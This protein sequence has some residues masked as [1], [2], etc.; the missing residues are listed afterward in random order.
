MSPISNQFDM[1]NVLELNDREVSS[2]R[3][4]TASE[5]HTNQVSPR[6]ASIF[7]RNNCGIASKTL[8]TTSNEKT[9]RFSLCLKNIVC[10]GDSEISSIIMSMPPQRQIIHASP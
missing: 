6:S 1:I 9:I 2:I 4:L 8:S 3:M 10:F 7:G 5:S